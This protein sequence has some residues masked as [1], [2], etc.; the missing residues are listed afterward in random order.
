MPAQ[1]IDGTAIARDIR[2]QINAGIR[3]KQETHTRYKPS[4][5]IIQG[6]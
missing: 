6:L 5:V 2:E 3:E 4:L 1:K